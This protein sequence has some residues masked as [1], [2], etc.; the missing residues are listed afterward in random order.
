ME[1]RNDELMHYGRKGM[2]WGE[3]IYGKKY[4]ASETRRQVESSKQNYKSSKQNYKTAKRKFDRSYNEAQSYSSRH[5][6]TQY[7]RKSRREESN[8]LWEQA[9]KDLAETR[10]SKQAYKDAKSQYKTAKDNRKDEINRTSRNLVLD[11]DVNPNA[12]RYIA[13]NLVD[14]NMTIEEAE[15]K[16]KTERTRNTIIGVMAVVGA[17]VVL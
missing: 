12:A 3:H 5:P 16:Y 11:N 1:Q 13:K 6:V 4:P 14:N 10:A 2:K 7:I 15:K 9:D 17:Y 8:A